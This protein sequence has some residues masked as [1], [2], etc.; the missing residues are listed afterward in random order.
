MQKNILDFENLCL[1]AQ[2]AQQ[3]IDYQPQTPKTYKQAL[4]RLDYFTEW[5]PAME[6]QYRYLQEHE[7]WRKVKRQ[8]KEKHAQFVKML[9][10]CVE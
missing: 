1:T 6:R 10:L 9:G 4:R 7:T 8:G 3:I 2:K 5:R